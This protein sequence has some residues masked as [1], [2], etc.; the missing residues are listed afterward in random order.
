MI[1]FETFRQYYKSDVPNCPNAVIEKAVIEAVIEWCEATMM[2]VVDAYEIMVASELA[3]YDLDFDEDYEAIAIKTAYFGD[4][5]NDDTRV[6]VTS[7]RELNKI[8]NWHVLTTSS[9]PSH[10]YLT[11][12]GQCRVYP[13][14]DD[15]IDDGLRMSCA[16]KPSRSATQVEDVIYNDHVEDIR[17]GVLFRLFR[18]KG[19]PWYDSEYADRHEANWISAK[20]RGKGGVLKGKNN[21]DIVMNYSGSSMF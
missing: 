10:V 8:S 21:L 19:R 11:R 12:A 4:G 18:M 7:E 6:T 15:D 20:G 1:T 9:N 2:V 13:I 3:E 17:H 16:V 5:S 14:A